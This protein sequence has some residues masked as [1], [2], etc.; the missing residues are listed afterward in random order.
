MVTD[1]FDAVISP[2]KL[3]SPVFEPSFTK[4]ILDDPSP[5]CKVSLSVLKNGSDSTNEGIVVPLLILMYKLPFN[6]VIFFI[7]LINIMH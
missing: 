3:M 7:L 6:Y 2:V 4:V 1:I 5:I